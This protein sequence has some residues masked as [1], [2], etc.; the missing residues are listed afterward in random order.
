VQLLGDLDLAGVAAVRG[1][2]LAAL[3]EGS[4]DGGTL[5]LTAVTTLSSVG[6]G[7]L[8]EVVGA[9]AAPYRVLLPP[10][11][12]ARRALDLTGLTPVLAPGTAG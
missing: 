1:P 6:M 2:L 8:V 7:L 5:D 10:G 11:G 12:P 9:A 4:A 3:T